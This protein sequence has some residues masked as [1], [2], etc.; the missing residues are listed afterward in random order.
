MNTCAFCG[1]EFEPTPRAPH[2]KYHDAEC[3]R[4]ASRMKDRKP[5]A[6]DEGGANLTAAREMVTALRD[7]GRLETV[8][9]SRVAMFLTLAGAVDTDPLN[10][11]LWREYRAAEA[12][13]RELG[14]VEADAFDDLLRGINETT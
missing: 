9:E 6:T 7:M 2:Q 4:K 5:T 3:R 14:V 8:D 11:P 13:L 10:A 12:G 1:I